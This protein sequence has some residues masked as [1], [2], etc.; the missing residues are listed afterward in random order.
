[1]NSPAQQ[2]ETTMRLKVMAL[3]AALACGFVVGCGPV[4]TTAPVKVDDKTK[5]SSK[6]PDGPPAKTD[7]KKPETPVPTVKPPETPVK[8]PEAPK[9]PEKAPPAPPK[10]PEK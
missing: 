2:R 10:S 7:D 5:L 8:P 9:P 6:G 4:A 1:M 3:T